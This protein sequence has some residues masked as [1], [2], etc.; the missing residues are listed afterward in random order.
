[1]P[2]THHC[3]SLVTRNLTVEDALTLASSTTLEFKEMTAPVTPPSGALFVYAKSGGKLYA[4]SDAGI[5]LDLTAG[6]QN[7]A[8]ILYVENPI[9]TDAFPIGY[10]PQAATLVAL[11]AVTDAGTIDFNIEKRSK[12]TPDVAGSNAW[13]VDKQASASGLEQTIF[14]AGVIAADQWLYFAASAVASSPMKLWVS[15]EYAID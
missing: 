10:V 3:D 12:L 5:E 14:D 11:R 15:V 7:V 13:T 2:I 9:A 1:M 6:K 4:K 8:K